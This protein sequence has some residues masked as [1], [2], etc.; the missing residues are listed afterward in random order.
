LR[1]AE[2]HHHH[3]ETGDVK[4]RSL[5]P[6]PGNA[7]RPVFF[8]IAGCFGLMLVGY[9]IF[10][11]AIGLDAASIVWITLLIVVVAA[12]ALWFTIHLG[13]TLQRD[14]AQLDAG[15]IWAEWTVPEEPFRRF[16]A[17]EGRGKRRQAFACAAGGVATGLALG[18]LEGDRLLA[19]II[20][21]VFLLAAL[22]IVFLA[23][24][25]RHANHDDGRHIRIGPGGVRLLG[26]YMP[27]E[28]TMTRLRAVDIADGDP[29]VMALTVRAGRGFVQIRV[30]VAPDQLGQAEAVA[31]RLRQVHGL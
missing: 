27:F 17:A 18:A 29:P 19:G 21:V 31:E 25:P 12:G 26:R 28:T 7:A 20:I 11:Y 24:T 30:P 4:A 2:Y 6:Q 5:I 22:V 9:S 1:N 10:M 13:R 23:G 14:E 8:L 16:V 3:Q 15:E